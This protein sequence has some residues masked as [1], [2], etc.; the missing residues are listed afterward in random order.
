[1]EL[2]R[3]PSQKNVEVFREWKRK[4]PDFGVF[5]IFEKKLLESKKDIR[6]LNIG[7]QNI[8]PAKTILGIQRVQDD[9]LTLTIPE[10]DFTNIP[11]NYFD[12]IFWS[13]FDPETH[14]RDVKKLVPI[15]GVGTIYIPLEPLKKIFDNC[16]TNKERS[17]FPASYKNIGKLLHSLFPELSIK[18]L[19][20]GEEEFILL[21]KFEKN[22]G[23]KISII[24]FDQEKVVENII[25]GR[26]PCHGIP[27]CELPPNYVRD[28]KEF[29]EKVDNE[30][31]NLLDAGIDTESEILN[32]LSGF[33]Y[34]DFTHK[35]FKKLIRQRLQKHLGEAPREISITTRYPVNVPE[36]PIVSLSGLKNIGGYSCFMDSVLFTILFDR[37]GYFVQALKKDITLN[38]R[39]NCSD[40]D[41]VQKEL[42]KLS[43]VIHGEKQQTCYPIVKKLKECNVIANELL[44]ED[45][46]DDAEFLQVLMQ[47][48]DLEPTT[49]RIDKAVS[50]GEQTL[51]LRPMT[52][53]E[54]ILEVQLPE[55]G[56]VVDIIEWYQREQLEDYRK[57][58]KAD[59]PKGPD[60]Q[61]YPFLK[62][63]NT[64][65]DSNAL[66]LHVPRV[67]MKLEKYIKNTRPVSFAQFVDG[68]EKKYALKAVTIHKGDAQGG[69][70]TAFFKHDGVWFYYDDLKDQLQM[71]DWDTVAKQGSVN[72]SLFIYEVIDGI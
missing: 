7:E 6:S 23:E 32:Q 57:L 24:T 54:S 4:N 50:N 26:E 19:R 69:H 72:G 18:F 51:D 44:D 22:V 16:L 61:H 31:D 43:N 60:G 30:I 39:K 66:I 8:E 10:T 27:N 53:K 71:S 9:T 37:Q 28:V 45:Q 59:Q 48:F 56:D 29:Y 1:M 64:I 33:D 2:T 67:Q 5:E 11:F 3:K 38:M 17:K 62:T 21:H 42:V 63:S 41:S 13:N 20:Y 40:I 52:V 14:L 68:G 65:V 12:I 47:I 34:S 25:S 46:Q 70:Y 49:I 36:L 35:M 15:L 55:N 58:P